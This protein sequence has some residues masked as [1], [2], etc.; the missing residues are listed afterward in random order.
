MNGREE[1]AHRMEAS[2]EARLSA[3]ED[4]LRAIE[5]LLGVGKPAPEPRP[6]PWPAQHAPAPRA[7]QPPAPP[8]EPFDLEELLGGRV[9]GWVGGIAVVVAAVFFVATAIHNGWIGEAARVVLAFAAAAALTAGGIFLYERKGRTQAARAATAAGIAAFYASDT[10]ATALY[11]LVAPALGLAIAGLVGAVATGLAVR[12][13]SLEIAGIGLV[14]ALLAPVLVD[15]GTSS[16]SLVFMALA[17]CATVGVLIWRRWSWLAALAY[18]VSV[19]QAADWLDHEY[20]QHLATAL[21]VTGAFWLLYIVAAIGYELRDPT[22]RLRLASASLLFTNA[23]LTALGGWAMLHDVGKHQGAT[24][25]V[26]GVAAAQVALGF[27]A[28]LRTRVSRE[29]GA[30]LVAVGSALGAVGLALALDGPVLVA[31]WALEGVLL[32]WVARRAEDRRGF[33]PAVGF[34]G[35]AAVHTLF[36]EAKP[37]ALAYG[38]DSL[39]KAVVSLVLVLVALV[40]LGFLIEEARDAL[41]LAAAVA[42]VYLGSVVVVDVV[43]RGQDGQLALSAFWAF[44]GLGGLVAGLVRD[45]KPLR[46]G[47]LAL[48][49][50][51][52][53]KVFIVDLARLGSIWRVASFLLIGL[54]LLTGAFAYQRMRKEQAT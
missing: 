33:V 9:L 39:P 40:A 22:T 7:P 44:L 3:I 18:V 21:V 42:A 17:L 24:A 35:G 54:L 4:R 12:W 6:E 45:L 1:E 16:A 8:R 48:L 29:V 36:F 53:G 14:G 5:Q 46:L 19:P 30:L 37:T 38:V 25:W 20:H 47:G 31:G 11:H 50:L 28:W 10:A 26:I 41:L 13:N 23:S 15:A 27:L 52:V 32:A 34:V 51:A 49:G 2:L 43:G